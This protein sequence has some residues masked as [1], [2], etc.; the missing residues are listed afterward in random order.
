VKA[1]D[2]LCAHPSAPPLSIVNCQYQPLDSDLIIYG[3][4]SRH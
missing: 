3:S 1:V 2:S 4:M